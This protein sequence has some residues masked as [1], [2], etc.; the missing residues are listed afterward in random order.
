MA[1]HWTAR[2]EPI[3][4]ISQGQPFYLLL[5]SAEALAATDCRRYT[6]KIE[7]GGGLC[8]DWILRLLIGFLG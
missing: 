4:G 6:S 1:V 3:F 7:Q 5:G 2:A 8:S